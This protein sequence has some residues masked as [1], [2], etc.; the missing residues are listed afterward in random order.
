MTWALTAAPRETGKMYFQRRIRDFE[1]RITTM[2][3]MARSMVN[4]ADTEEDRAEAQKWVR[5]LE[6]L[7][8]SLSESQE[9]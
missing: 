5:Y 8:R 4:A 7:G 9:D 6:R 2:L 3:A 1:T